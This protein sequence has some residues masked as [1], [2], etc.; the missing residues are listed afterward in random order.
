MSL[1]IDAEPLLDLLAAVDAANEPR[2]GLAKSY[3]ELPTP[4]TPAQTERFQAE[5]QKAST[6]WANA[7]GALALALV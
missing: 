4:V 6:E 3:R 1:M 2:Y 7:C 5:Y